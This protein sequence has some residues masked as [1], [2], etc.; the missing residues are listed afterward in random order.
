MKGACLAAILFVTVPLCFEPAVLQAQQPS[1]PPRDGG[2]A[3][4]DP[5]ATGRIRGQ[6]IAADT[7]APLAWATVLFTALGGGR[8][9]GSV[10]TDIRGR[11][12]LTG[13]SP[14]E[15]RVTALPPAHRARYLPAH[16]GAATP[17]ESGIAVRVA[18]GEIV[19]RIDITL[20]VAAAV[21]GRV[22]DEAG[23]PLAD[24]RVELLKAFDSSLSVDDP[25]PV[26]RSR[27]V[28]T[29]DAGQ[30]RLFG[31]V[32]GDYTLAALA[33]RSYQ[34][35]ASSPPTF[36]TTFY[37]SATDQTQSQRISVKPGQE[38]GGLEIRM[39]RSRT[40]GISGTVAM[41]DGRPIANTSVS[42]NR[43]DRLGGGGEELRLDAEGRFS[44]GG[45]TPGDYAI[46]ATPGGRTG[47]G[48]F[49]SVPLTIVDSD[50]KDIVVITR[51]TVTVSGRVTFDDSISNAKPSTIRLEVTAVDPAGKSQWI[52]QSVAVGADGSFTVSNLFMPVI[53]RPM[54][55]PEWGLKG[56]SLYRTDITDRPTEF[57]PRDSGHLE[58]VMTAKLSRIEGR[59]RD[60]PGRPIKDCAVLLFSSTSADWIPSSSRIKLAQIQSGGEF[61]FTDVRPGSYR[62]IAIPQARVTGGSL[63]RPALLEA[64]VN[65]ATDITVG[66]EE[67]RTVDLRL[68]SR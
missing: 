24:I 62:I 27:A 51:P 7:R 29:D 55:E 18:A 31:V 28:Y 48:E 50:I 58:V 38:T 4:S 46:V 66:E 59:V 45:L 2:R 9:G 54:G 68:V 61:S 21:A 11:F 17:Y 39:V 60:D 15:Y 3:A 5:V 63:H 16:F 41:S 47:L 14:G 25:V 26:G 19:E 64:L 30:F 52:P 40:F 36:I 57:Q 8:Q 10:Q 6:V 22:V 23:E 35:T 49:A 67:R 12:E 44:A 53:I 1:L 65:D 37:P 20:A 43:Y 13:L 34:R 32:E 56:V 42:L 33:E